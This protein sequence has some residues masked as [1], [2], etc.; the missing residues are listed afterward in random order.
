MSDISS[1]VLQPGMVFR[2]EDLVMVTEN[3]VEVLNK[4]TKELIEI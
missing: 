4:F 3:G 2:I 1:T